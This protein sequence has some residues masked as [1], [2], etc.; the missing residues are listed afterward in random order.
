MKKIIL[1]ISA[2]TAGLY[3][4]S[5]QVGYFIHMEFNLSSSFE[6]YYVVVGLWI[7]GGIAGLLIRLRRL[8]PLLLLIGL[9]A[10]YLHY[11]ILRKFP[12][13]MRMMPLYMV[14]VFSTALYSGY[15][16]RHAR[17]DFSSVKSLFFH[18]NNGFI[19]GYIVAVGV[20]LLHG[21]L[22]QNILPSITAFG[23]LS[24]VFILSRRYSG[25]SNKHI[26]TKN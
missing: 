8:G 11:L 6:S 15:F 10:F 7:L 19:C 18:E 4:A 17:K 3:F 24:L 25:K 5:C 12:Y 21:H 13:D 9:A 14:F 1:N 23:H 22:S 2:F 26:T 16:F 20:L